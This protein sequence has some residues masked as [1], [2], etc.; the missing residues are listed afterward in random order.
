MTEK[1]HTHGAFFKHL[2]SHAAEIFKVVVYFF[3]CLVILQTFRCATLLVAM[4]EN[5]FINSYTTAALTAAVLGKCV[6]V[7][8]KVRISQLLDR[9]PVFTI[10]I[11]KT[12]LFTAA[13]NVILCVEHLIRE[14]SVS[15][16]HSFGDPL[17][18]FIG[19]AAHQLALIVSFG[20][21]FSAR[22]LDHV[23]GSG[24]I[25]KVILSNREQGRAILAALGD[26]GSQCTKPEVAGSG[27]SEENVPPDV[28]VG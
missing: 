7:L 4:S 14:H 1:A 23:L 15:P 26:E 11:Y 18:D 13:T 19:F 8:E 21:F 9:K 3:I 24:T 5:Q 16:Y 12:I 28:V 17:K 22:E 20:L 6:F 10:V 2:F 27:S 25:L